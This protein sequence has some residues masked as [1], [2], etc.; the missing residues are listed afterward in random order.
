MA[1]DVEVIQVNKGMELTLR[2]R[3]FF[4][5][6]Q[7][8]VD[9]GI[10]DGRIQIQRGSDGLYWDGAAWVSGQ[11]WNATTVDVGGL[12]DEYDFMVPEGGED[13]E[14]YIVSMQHNDDAVTEVTV[15]FAVGTGGGGG[16]PTSAGEGG[17]HM[18]PGGVAE[19]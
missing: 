3:H 5:D 6:H 2:H 8:G 4:D 16:G 15:H 19:D 7:Y 17:S 11:T 12:F 10:P 1:E 13:V 14:F 9:N 18:S